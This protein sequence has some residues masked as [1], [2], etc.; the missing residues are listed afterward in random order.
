MI[1]KSNPR[2]GLL[3]RVVGSAPVMPPPS[4]RSDRSLAY[5]TCSRARRYR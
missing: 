4:D 2:L 3:G 1:S 5:K